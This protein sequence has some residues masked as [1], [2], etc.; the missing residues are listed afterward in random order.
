MW[1]CCDTKNRRQTHNLSRGLHTSRLYCSPILSRL[2][3]PRY[4][5]RIRIRIH[6]HSRGTCSH[7]HT[8]AQSDA[9]WSR[10]SLLSL[11]LSL[12]VSSVVAADSVVYETYKTEIPFTP[13]I[14]CL[15]IFNFIT[16]VLHCCRVSSVLCVRVAC[17]YYTYSV[18]ASPYAYPAVPSAPISSP[19]IPCSRVRNIIPELCVPDPQVFSDFLQ[20]SRDLRYPSAADSIVFVVCE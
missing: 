3:I 8:R 19:R 11:F 1:R 20:T 6:A 2:T 7:A 9:G 12:A 18:S 14:I 16:S 15:S 13:R 10:A 4:I 5:M 17:V